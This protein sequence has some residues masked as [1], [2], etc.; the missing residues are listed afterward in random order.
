MTIPVSSS[1]GP[2]RL[3][4]LD[5]PP[6]DVPRRASIL[7]RLVDLRRALCEPLLDRKV[8]IVRMHVTANGLL[9]VIWILALYGNCLESGVFDC[10]PVLL[11]WAARMES[12]K[13][14]KRFAAIELI[15]HLYDVTI[16]T[17]LIPISRH[18]GL[19]SLFS[20]WLSTTLAI[21]MVTTYTLFALVLIHG[22]LHVA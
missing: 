12:L 22:F 1:P 3:V 13:E 15:D 14:T 20:L 6:R 17:V 19:A 10:E 21:H 7:F 18:S 8:L 11:N 9:A 5:I 4:H 2:C 16:G